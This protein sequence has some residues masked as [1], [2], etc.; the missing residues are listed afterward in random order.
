MDSFEPTGDDLNRYRSYLR[1]LARAQLDDRLQARVDPSDIVQETLL[2]AHRSLENFEGRSEAELAGWLRRILSRRLAHAFRDHT[3]ERRDVRREYSLEASLATSATHLEQFTR[4]S[5]SP[6]EV[7]S[8]AERT[9][10]LADA[11]ESLTADQR[12]AIIRHYFQGHTVPQIAASMQKSESAIGGLL[13]R[14]M[15]ALRRRLRKIDEE[16]HD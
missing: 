7:A 11:M 10:R 13:H 5:C 15:Q 16:S 12:E 1:L 3:R 4:D 6:S 2:E 9:Q 8:R 14:G